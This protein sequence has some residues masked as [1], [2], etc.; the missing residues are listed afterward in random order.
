MVDLNKGY[1]NPIDDPNEPY[2]WQDIIK[3]APICQELV[4]NY[5]KIKEEVVEFVKNPSA[6]YNYPKYTVHYD[7]QTY[8]LYAHYWKASPMSIFEKE[9]IDGGANPFQLQIL[10]DVIKNNKKKCPTIN[11]VIFPLE[12]EGNLRN[13][14]VSRLIP[15]S[16][17]RPH[18]GTSMNFMRIHLGLVCDPGCKITVGKETRTWEEGKL[19]AFKDGGPYLHSVKHE[20]TSE[21]IVLSCDVRIDP[22]LLPYMKI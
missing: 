15:G 22:Y 10:Y 5:E 3:D 17:I 6:L 14:F 1:I 9:Y 12:S 8:D 21:R 18:D 19:I 16:H 2:F 7:H 13:S 4:A 11:K 20:G